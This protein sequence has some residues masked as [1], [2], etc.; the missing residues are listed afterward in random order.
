M[1]VFIVANMGEMLLCLFLYERNKP[2]GG[3]PVKL[4]DFCAGV[5]VSVAKMLF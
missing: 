3:A 1:K 4:F 5:C 2:V